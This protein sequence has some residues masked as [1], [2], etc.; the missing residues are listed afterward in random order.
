M[1]MS[2]V[3]VLASY[4]RNDDNGGNSRGGQPERK[5]FKS[6]QSFININIFV[7]AIRAKLE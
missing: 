6:T 3:L 1:R 2:T 5:T 4:N 7:D